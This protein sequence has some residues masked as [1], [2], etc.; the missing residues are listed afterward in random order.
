VLRSWY[1][2]DNFLRLERAKQILADTRLGVGQVATLVGKIAGVQKHGFDR[3]GQQRWFFQISDFATLM[4]PGKWEWRNPVR[5]TTV[6]D[7]GIELK[8]LK[9]K[10][11]PPATVSPPMAESAPSVK[12][13]TIAE[14]KAAAQA[15]G[16]EFHFHSAKDKD[17]IAHAFAEYVE[18]GAKALLIN[19][20]PLF[21][22]ERELILG[23]ATRRSVP[24]IY[25][26]RIF[27]A[28]GGLM[29]Y[30][31]SLA[32]LFRQAGVYV[33]RILKG[34]KP[35]DL[36]VLQPTNFELVINLKAAKELALSIPATLLASASEVIE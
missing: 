2:E 32:D 17:E 12:P 31:A 14:A 36:P 21:I 23:L 20:D 26:D 30:G 35:A 5:Y 15:V 27:A 9:F 11:A 24:T 4:Q 18:L 33:G 13:L 8:K 7:L 16:V 29:S 3:R 10:P 1:S 22:D 19:P 25:F 28:S 6:E 34:E